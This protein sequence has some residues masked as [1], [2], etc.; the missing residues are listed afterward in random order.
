MEK[1]DFKPAER[2]V[3]EDAF[4]VYNQALDVIAKLMTA[5]G[6]LPDNVSLQVA[7]DRSGFI[8]QGPIVLG[9]VGPSGPIPLDKVS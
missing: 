9:P 1:V 2:K 7:D 3:L 8:I 6:R 4:K 5:E